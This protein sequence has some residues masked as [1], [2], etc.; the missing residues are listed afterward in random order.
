MALAR[1]KIDYNGVVVHR[2]VS[3]ELDSDKI[4]RYWFGN[5]PWLT[6]WMNAI[7]GNVPV[8]E[9]FVMKATRQQLDKI[10]DPSIRKAAVSFIHQEGSHA[11]AHDGLNKVL[12][13]QGLPIKESQVLVQAIFDAYENYMPDVM[14]FAFSATGE[15][16]TAT[17]STVMM[18]NPE[19]WDETPDEVA[20][21]AFWH[22]VEEIE[23][24]SVSMDIYRDTCGDNAYSYAVLM[25]TLALGLSTLATAAHMSWFYLLWKDRQ[26][27]NLRSAFKAARK[28]LFKPGLFRR[29]FVSETLPFLSP[30]FHPW[31]NDNREMINAWKDCYE[32]TGDPV[33]AYH[34]FR[35]WHDRKHGKKSQAGLARSAA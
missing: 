1:R 27:T 28:M 33:Q 21:L 11:K 24:K 34:A 19:L 13:A 7:F 18:E 12:E 35:A 10:S 5:D 17:L 32:E 14:K 20:A 3:F 25:A 4:P 26:I 16:F 23:H 31:D 8:G 6:H 22:F 15:H 2:D 29:S 9:R 30:R